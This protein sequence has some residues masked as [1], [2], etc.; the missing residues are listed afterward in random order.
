MIVKLKITSSSPIRQEI[1]SF[2]NAQSTATTTL[3]PDGR[4]IYSGSWDDTEFFASHSR[5][6][7]INFDQPTTQSLYSNNSFGIRQVSFPF[8]PSWGTPALAIPPY[9]EDTANKTV[10]F[11]PLIYLAGN[12]DR[13]FSLQVIGHR[14][15]EDIYIDLHSGKIK[16][17]TTSTT[18]VGYSVF[19]YTQNIDEFY[20]CDLSLTE[21]VGK[22]HN[23]LFAP[24]CLQTYTPSQQ[25]IDK[26]VSELVLL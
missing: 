26:I 21:V 20:G 22:D 15:P 3:V 10:K 24:P 25:L 12:V 5:A 9:N 23:Y 18:R 6:E 11:G 13:G 1:Q 7:Q 2:Q 4:R 19:R 14:S 16:D 17:V 8:N